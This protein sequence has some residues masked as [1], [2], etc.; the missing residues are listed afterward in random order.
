M[1]QCWLN[2]F[3]KFQPK[4]TYIYS[5]HHHDRNFLRNS[6]WSLQSRKTKQLKS[7]YLNPHIS[8]H[9]NNQLN[10]HQ[11]HSIYPEII[12]F[13]TVIERIYTNN[14]YQISIA[15]KSVFAQLFNSILVPLIVNFNIKENI[16]QKG[17][18]SEDIFILA[19]FNSLLPPFVRLIDPY[20]IFVYLRYTYY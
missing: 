10:H 1:V 14:H 4:I 3:P 9:R 16:F 15:I 6:V 20:G 17:G 8:S 11:Y 2:K 5:H 13:T 12:Q 18:L 19:I 7:L